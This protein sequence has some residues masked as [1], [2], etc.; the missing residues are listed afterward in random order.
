VEIE[1]IDSAT[2]T[3]V[4]VQLELEK[5]QLGSVAVDNSERISL[6][7]TDGAARF[8]RIGSAFLG[9]KFESAD[10]EL[11]DIHPADTPGLSAR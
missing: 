3:A 11:I 7:A 9:R 2:T 8:A 5:L 10:I 4:A 6:V 1:I